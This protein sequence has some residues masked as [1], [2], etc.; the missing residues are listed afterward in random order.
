MVTSN[1]TANEETKL[2]E[3]GMAK[4]RQT[5]A[6]ITRVELKIMEAVSVPPKSGGHGEIIGKL[7]SYQGAMKKLKSQ[8]EYVVEH[9]RIEGLAVPTTVHEL[10]KKVC[11]DP[12]LSFHI[13]FLKVHFKLKC[14]SHFEFVLF[15]FIP[16]VNSR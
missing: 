5:H 2:W 8:Y 13:L 10:K 4:V 3:L 12:F 16:N 7:Q 14:Y 9:Q 15:I 11:E 1:T 6:N